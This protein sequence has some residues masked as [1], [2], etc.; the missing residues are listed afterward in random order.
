MSDPGT[1]GPPVGPWERHGWLMGAIWLVFLGFL[2]QALLTLETGWGWRLAGLALLAVFVAVYLHGLI[3]IPD[4][5]IA[6]IQPLGLLHVGVLVALTVLLYLL[7]GGPATGTLPYVVALSMFTLRLV[8]AVGLAVLAIATPLFLDLTGVAESGTMF[9]ALIITLVAVTT[10]IVRLI[11]ERDHGY[12]E[13]TTELII[14]AERDRVARDVHD[15]LGH[16]LTVVTAKAELAER[17]VEVD[18]ERSRQELAEIRALT[19]SALADIRETVSGLR[20]GGLD[21]ELQV[22]RETLAAAEIAADLPDGADAVDPRHRLVLAWV[23]REAVTNVVRHSGAAR[24]QVLVSADGLQV[25]DDGRGVGG[26]PE[27]NGLRGLRER[28]RAA[29]GTLSI[30]PGPDGHGTTLAVT[31]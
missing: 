7:V 6:Q 29:G 10:L 16:S 30:G 21:G 22:A 11:E 2:L 13:M 19:R 31:L 5:P 17:L 24:C 28:V 26:A 15:V 23:L 12:R 27:G 1:E 25:T 14:A 20:T 4:A 18:P 3:R 9:M 8:W